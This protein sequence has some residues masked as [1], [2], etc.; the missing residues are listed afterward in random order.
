MVLL[1]AVFGYAVLPDFY[2]YQPTILVG[3]IG[4]SY[5]HLFLQF[6]TLLWH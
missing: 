4:G 5:W 3:G 2:I 6:K 1:A